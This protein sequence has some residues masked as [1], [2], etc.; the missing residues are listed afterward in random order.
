MQWE[1]GLSWKYDIGTGGRFELV[2]LEVSPTSG[3]PVVRD[4]PLHTGMSKWRGGTMEDVNRPSYLLGPP[5]GMGGSGGVSVER[6]THWT[7]GGA[8][9]GVGAVRPYSA[10]EQEEQEWREE[11]ELDSL[12]NTRGGVA[13]ALRLGTQRCFYGQ[14][15]SRVRR[16][17][18]YHATCCH[19]RQQAP[20]TAH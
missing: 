2:H 7:Y 8:D 11:G 16:T 5:W 10:Q 13:V 12:C 4:W 9:P 18:L 1:G 6:G 3:A 14:H 15:V 17:R 19:M 20:Q